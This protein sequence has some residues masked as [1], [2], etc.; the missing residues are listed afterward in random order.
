MSTLTSY[1]IYKM[2]ISS[3]NQIY[4]AGLIFVGLV[5]DGGTK[6]LKTAEAIREVAKE[7]KKIGNMLREKGQE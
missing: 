4:G 6:V 5:L 7:A 1:D 3:E 2:G